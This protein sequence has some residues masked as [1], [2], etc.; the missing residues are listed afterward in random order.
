MDLSWGAGERDVPEAIVEDTTD[1]GA[2]TRV[3]DRGAGDGAGGGEQA[4]EDEPR[5]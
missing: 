1:G 5:L 2:L 4:A 3:V